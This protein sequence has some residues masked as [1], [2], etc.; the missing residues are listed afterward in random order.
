[1]GSK[2]G[3]KWIFALC[4]IFGANVVFALDFRDSNIS[5]KN[6]D[7]QNLGAIENIENFA[8]SE[9][10]DGVRGIWDGLT[11]FSKRGKKLAIPPCFAE[12]LAVL[13]LQNGEFVEGE[14]WSGYGDFE[15]ISSLIR[16]KNPTCKDFERVKFLI[17]NAHLNES[18][19]FLANLVRISS[20]LRGDKAAEAIQ[21]TA[22]IQVI[23]QHKFS[24]ANE[25]GDFFNAIIAKGGEGVILRDSHRLLS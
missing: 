14:F 2:I 13:N 7:L 5:F 15:K 9:K 12:K 4:A 25:V 11:M 18:S 10:F 21:K 6:L 24:N 19:D 17:F 20:S 1:M 23:A 16:R 3:V 22:Q 8:V